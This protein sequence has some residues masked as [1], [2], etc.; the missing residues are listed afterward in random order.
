MNDLLQPSLILNFILFG[1]IVGGC[2]IA[3]LLRPWA[4]PSID[5]VYGSAASG[6]SL[7]ASL[8]F[9]LALILLLLWI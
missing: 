8:L 2:L 1:I 9:L 7:M 5:Y 3:V 6:G 4:R